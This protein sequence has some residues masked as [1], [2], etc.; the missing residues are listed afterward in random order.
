MGEMK[1]LNKNENLKRFAVIFGTDLYK[2]NGQNYDLQYEFAEETEYETFDNLE[3][4]KELYNN[5]NL[6]INK[7]ANC[8]YA[9]YKKLI[10][11]KDYIKYNENNN[12]DFSKIE[13]VLSES[14]YEEILGKSEF[15]ENSNE[16]DVKDRR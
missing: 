4:A 15:E 8:L 13:Q 2:K 7:S 5:I 14:N 3:E 16:E 1:L 11:I 10:E 6:N 12:D 9:Q